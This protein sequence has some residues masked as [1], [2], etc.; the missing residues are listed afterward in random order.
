MVAGDFNNSPKDL[1]QLQ[2]HEKVGGQLVYPKVNTCTAGKGAVLD[3]MVVQAALAQLL[4][5]I[6]VDT[7][8]PSNPHHPVA[9]TFIG[10]MLKQHRWELTKAPTMPKTLP[11]GP[12]N[13][14]PP[15]A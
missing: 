8:T 6:K 14:P 12:I 4:T 10:N 11:K 5:S 3:Y 15:M 2:W 1:E 9:A 7:D 13:Q